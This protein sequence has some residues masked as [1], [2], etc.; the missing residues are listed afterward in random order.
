MKLTIIVI[1]MIIKEILLH[2][3]DPRELITKLHTVV[4]FM[5]MKNCLTVCACMS[6]FFYTSV[7]VC[8]SQSFMKNNFQLEPKDLIAI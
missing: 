3:D 5:Y 6:L 4:H 8:L 2:F 7:F 1:M